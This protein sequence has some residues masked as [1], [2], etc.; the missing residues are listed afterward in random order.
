MSTVEE[1]TVEAPATGPCVLHVRTNTDVHYYIDCGSGDEATD[2]ENQLQERAP[3][4]FTFT[5]HEYTGSSDVLNAFPLPNQEAAN[6]QTAP[7]ETTPSAEQTSTG[8]GSIPNDT[9]L[10][11]LSRANLDQLLTDNGEDPSQYANK[12]EA[13]AALQAL[14]G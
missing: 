13:I 10:E 7:T 8:V 12:A 3:G 9:T 1:E 14:R 11:S 2:L 4:N 6:P 5:T